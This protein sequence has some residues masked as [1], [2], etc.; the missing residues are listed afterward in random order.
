TLSEIRQH[1]QTYCISNTMRTKIQLYI[2]C[3]LKQIGWIFAE[4]SWYSEQ[5]T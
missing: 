2:C 1:M 3:L 4:S 5:H